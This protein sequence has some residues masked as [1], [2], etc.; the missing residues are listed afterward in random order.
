MKVVK[1]L[2]LSLIISFISNA[3]SFNNRSKLRA[4]EIKKAT[5]IESIKIISQDLINAAVNGKLDIISKYLSKDLDTS[6]VGAND[7]SL[8]FT[9]FL[10]LDSITVSSKGNMYT[11]Q[12]IISD[13]VTNHKLSEIMAL[14]HSG[15]R[16]EIVSST[17]LI[18]LLIKQIKGKVLI[19]SLNNKIVVKNSNKQIPATINNIALSLN[20]KQNTVQSN[21]I[22]LSNNALVR[23]DLGTDYNGNT[24][25]VLNKSVAQNYLGGEL[26]SYPYDGKIVVMNGS[27]DKFCVATDNSWDRIIYSSENG[28]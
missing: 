5:D 2:I 18:K 19:N 20:L 13:K 12:C 8:I 11:M 27:G 1:V 21:S 25:M 9:P 22:V 28:Q 6:Y 15:E 4:I 26:F 17:F 24:I 23:T 10:R 16:W 3:Q 14:R 7:T